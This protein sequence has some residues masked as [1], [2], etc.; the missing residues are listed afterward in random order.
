[1]YR[2]SFIKMLFPWFMLLAVTSCG[3]T[4]DYAGGG[5]GGTGITGISVGRITNFG[6]VWV[7]GV[8]YSTK[9][10]II[11]I[12]GIESISNGT[13]EY[14][15]N[16]LDKGK[17]VTVHWERDAN[18]NAVAKR[19]EF[20]DNLEGVVTNNYYPTSQTI[21]VLGQTVKV[22]AST[23]FE[24]S[25]TGEKIVGDS[26]AILGAIVT[27][28]VIEVSGFVVD[29]NGTIQATYL[30][31]KSL[32]FTPGDTKVEIKGFIMN[33]VN[34]S[35]I[36]TFTIGTLTVNCNNATE[37]P[38][39]GLMND[40]YVE[41]KGTLDDSGLV[42]N[43]TKIELEDDIFE[44]ISGKKIEIEGIVTTIVDVNGQFEVNRRSVRIITGTTLCENCTIETD[45][46]P[47]V[48]VEVEGTVDENGVI[49]ADKIEIESG[50]DGNDDSEDDSSDDFDN[51]AG[52]DAP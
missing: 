14:D 2:W 13:T 33:L 16:L 49:V 40:L 48:K 51:D 31:L 20:K 5:I 39:E 6:S 37:L 52:D 42:L 11:A 15:S 38:S 50:D 25:I 45:I 47:G 21:E 23:E 44:E 36:C 4:T 1:M 7:N 10:A 17:I 41:V 43:A 34:T 19:I 24:N 28:N 22:D 9:G 18:G 35:E 12:E 32:E 46:L 30:E 26:N 29:A 8:E 27:G 3:T